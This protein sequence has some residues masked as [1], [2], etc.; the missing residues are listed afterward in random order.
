[1]EKPILKNLKEALDNN[2][3]LE[4]DFIGRLDE[5]NLNIEKTK[6]ELGNNLI[7]GVENKADTLQKMET[8]KVAILS[9]LEKIRE[10]IQKNKID[11]SEV[12]RQ[13]L[14]ETIDNIS[15]EANSLYVEAA[16]SLLTAV[17]KLNQ[18][19]GLRR[20]LPVQMRSRTCKVLRNATTIDIKGSI[21]NLLNRMISL[22]PDIKGIYSKSLEKKQR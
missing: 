17:D 8:D 22:H 1:M 13:S 9:A 3:K 15:D 2:N 20:K 18:I 7:A 21:T 5:L 10:T 11:I 6:Q 4:A 14:I 16:Q 12:E 19:D